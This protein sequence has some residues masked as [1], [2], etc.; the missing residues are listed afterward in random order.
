VVQRVV[1]VPKKGGGSAR[2]PVKPP[3]S[4]GGVSAGGK[5]FTSSQAKAAFIEYIQAG[6]TVAAALER[7][8]RAQ[9][10]YE[11]W[12]KTDE[13]FK[14]N[15]DTVMATRKVTTTD[16]DDAKLAARKMG[17][18][19]WRMKY[20][21]LPTYWHQLQWIDLIEGRDPR[22]L[23]PAQTFEVG[24]RRNRVVVN[25]PPFHA[26][27]MTVSIDY[28]TYRICCNPGVRI[29]IISKTQ[30]M[31]KKFL[32]AIKMRMTHPRY[33]QLIKDFAPEGGFEQSAEQ[34]TG[35][36][37]TLAAADRDGVEKDPTVQALGIGGQVYGA[38]ADLIIVDDAVT[39]A[40]ANEWEK[41]LDWISQE[42][43]SRPG[44]S[45]KIL[46]VGTRVSANDLY[47]QLRNPDNYT[48]GISPWTYLSQ[49]AILTD[50]PDPKNWETLWPR[51]TRSWWDEDEGS[52]E[53]DCG[54]PECQHG[55]GDGAYPRWDGVHL[56]PL[57]ENEARWQLVFMQ[58]AIAGD[59]AFPTHALQNATNRARRHGKDGGM[60][61]VP[62]GMHIVA[63]LDPATSGAAAFVVGAVDKFTG[64]RWIYDVWNVKHPTPQELKDRVRSITLEYGVHEWR[65][66]KTGLLTMFTQ[67]AGL[68]RW[69]AAR[70][71]RLVPHYT[72]SNKHDVGF[73]VG[74][75]SSLFGVYEQ[76]ED[77]FREVM[78]P[79]IELPRWEGD[80]QQ[81]V[82]QLQIWHSDLDP[83]K[84][85]IDLVMALWFFDIGCR[86]WVLAGSTQNNRHRKFSRMAPAES[87]RKAAVVNLN[88]Y[89]S[90]G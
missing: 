3:R 13:D 25:C 82:H 46:V 23:H 35:D 48:S 72:G 5:K 59:A 32:G 29:I 55:Y 88:D 49:P 17:F 78:P 38:R 22:D 68:N 67:D 52:N 14:S 75:M 62:K 74:S 70:G 40:N 37:V 42:V 31:A 36:I 50:D 11:Y 80:I 18:A 79:V 44:P 27:S 33:A 4:R 87:R 89:R 85:P 28:A 56:A 26:K 45:G 8:E 34:W 76:S 65:I 47:Y 54:L 39:L 12:R 81:L 10:T 9:K 57:R 16:R 53:C 1:S 77:G 69:L 6:Y 19:E 15:V 2:N 43:G 66:E 71:V 63:S 58:S 20:L 41:Q 61:S 86:D 84:T 24:R 73:G 51:A 83:K 7:V 90:V 30:G 21:G 64:K 60:A